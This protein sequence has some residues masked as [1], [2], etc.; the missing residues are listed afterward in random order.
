MARQIC[1]P[2]RMSLD[3]LSQRIDRVAGAGD[4]RRRSALKSAIRSGALYAAPNVCPYRPTPAG[5]FSLT[6][7]APRPH[8]RLSAGRPVSQYAGN[9]GCAGLAGPE[10]HA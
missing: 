3:N 9:E 2:Q 7:V 6:E 8:V 1:S 10:P 4:S 5:R